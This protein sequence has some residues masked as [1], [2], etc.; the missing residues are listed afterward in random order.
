MKIGEIV[1]P[2]EKGQIVIPK[3]YRK[4]LGI[5]PNVSLNVVLTE[6]GI[7]LYPVSHV[8]GPKERD[9]AYI[10]I[11]KKTQGKWDEDWEPLEKRKKRVE[12]AAAK[13]RRKAW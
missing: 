7:H 11:L 4:A 3:A 6:E 10:N 2:N 9:I 13:K 8:I 12:Y 1:S 5:T